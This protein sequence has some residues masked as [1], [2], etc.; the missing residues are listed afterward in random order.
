MTTLH[1][2]RWF[3][4][5]H[6]RRFMHFV[7]KQDKLIIY[8]DFTSQDQHNLIK[9]ATYLADRCYWLTNEQSSVSGIHNITHHQ[10]LTLIAEHDKTYTWK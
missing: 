6:C 2:Y 7:D 10:W 8:G 3:S 5:N 9:K 1:Q 4:L